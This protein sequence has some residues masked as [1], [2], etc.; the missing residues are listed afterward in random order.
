MKNFILIAIASLCLTSCT[1]IEKVLGTDKIENALPS[2][3]LELNIIAASMIVKDA[4]TT[5]SAEYRN[6]NLSDTEAATALDIIN[7]ARTA[8]NTAEEAYARG[9]G[10][11]DP[12]YVQ[13]SSAVELVLK[14]AKEHFKLSEE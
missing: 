2:E 13:M 12:V 7:Q 1:V 8:V 4:A 9:I 10:S 11:N 6:G 5:V 14:L 3:Q